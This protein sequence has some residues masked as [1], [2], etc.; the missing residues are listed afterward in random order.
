MDLPVRLMVVFL[1]LSI[2]VPVLMDTLEQNETR[3]LATTVENEFSRFA[4]AVSIA[5]YSGI[6]SVRTVVL[7]VPDGCIV[8]IGGEEHDQYSIRAVH[9]GTILHVRYMELPPVILIFEGDLHA[10]RH[11][12]S[13]VSS[14]HGGKASAEVYL[15]D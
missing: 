6:G 8:S 14:M 1:I 15:I 10:G 11:N 12:L 2:S 5:H 3:T 7:N 4:D 13:I 9:N